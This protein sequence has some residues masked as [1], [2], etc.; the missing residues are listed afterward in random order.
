VKRVHALR[1]ALELFDFDDASIESL[2]KLLLR[3]AFAPGFLRAPEGRRFLSA[4]FTIHAGLTRELYAIVRNQIP[5]GMHNTHTS[6][7]SHPRIF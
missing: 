7:T 1:G 6:I 4:L 5:T 3:A 2:K